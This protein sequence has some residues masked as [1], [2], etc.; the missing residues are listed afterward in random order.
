MHPR[1]E[2][3]A[4]VSKTRQWRSGIQVSSPL[5]APLRTHAGNDRPSSSKGLH[6]GSGPPV[7]KGGE[8]MAHSLLHP[9]VGVEDGLAAGS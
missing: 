9:G 7:G 5:C 2:G 4:S 1:S 3:C 6:G 8:E